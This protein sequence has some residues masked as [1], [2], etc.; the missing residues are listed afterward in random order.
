MPEYFLPVFL[1]MSFVVILVTA[2]R[3]VPEHK[4]LSVFRLGRK[5][6]E[7]G[8]GFVLLMPIIDRAFLIDAPDP[9]TRQAQREIAEDLLAT[10]Q[11]GEAT[12]RA[13]MTETEL[14]HRLMATVNFT[15]EDLARNRMGQVSDRQVQSLTRG[16]WAAAAFPAL[17]GLAFGIGMLAVGLTSKEPVRSIV[18]SGVGM[19]F[20]TLMLLLFSVAGWLLW[21][22]LAQVKAL[23]MV[24]A[25]E[26]RKVKSVEG[27]GRRSYIGG[28]RTSWLCHIGDKSFAISGLAYRI[29][30]DGE[31][32]RAYY[33]AST[34]HL[35]SIEPVG[36][37]TV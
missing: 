30:I 10:G 26:Q 36:S 14:L 17:I 27:Q 28:R 29:F 31:F 1:V 8:P 12:V 13:D 24:G 32:Y 23:H 21:T 15:A 34:E 3:I 33:T 11:Q 9:M 37:E 25:D 20:T 35:L 7:R 2:I 16:A 19:M 6:G 4:R 22:N 18:F 5:I